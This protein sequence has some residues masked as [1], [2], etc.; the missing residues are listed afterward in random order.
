[1]VTESVTSESLDDLVVSETVKLLA[2]VD[3]IENSEPRKAEFVKKYNSDFGWVRAGI[4]SDMIKK[5]A[6]NFIKKLAE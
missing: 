4:R 1:M 6:I 5:S 3:K 2:M